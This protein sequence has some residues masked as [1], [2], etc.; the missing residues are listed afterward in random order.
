MR[1]V[2]VRY[3]VKAGREAENEAL[4]RAVY[5]EL[6]EV[7][8][9]GFRYATFR[10]DERSFVHV[11][12]TDGDGPGAA[13]ASSPRSRRSRATSASAATSRPSSRELTRWAR[14]GSDRSCAM[15]I[16]VT[17]SAGH[18]GEAL[19]ACC[20]TTGVDVVG[21]DVLASPFTT[22]VGSV[23]DRGCVRRCM[24]GR[25]RGPARRDAAQ[26][27]RRLAP[28]ARTSSTR[29]ST[30]TLTLLEEA[31]AAGRRRASSSR[32]RRARSAAR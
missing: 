15:R 11:A 28:R 32:A 29:T 2:M 18:L 7:Q 26:A 25:R 31:V 1:Q 6:D 5:E 14:T 17:G 21:L 9:E 16:L 19:C 3:R 24:R 10:F 30:G 4:V 22:V 13:S 20:A 23:A 8:P 27:A 12:L